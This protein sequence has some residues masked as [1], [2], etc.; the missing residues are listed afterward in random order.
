MMMRLLLC[1]REQSCSWRDRRRV[2]VDGGRGRGGGG[3]DDR[4]VGR[5]VEESGR[6]QEI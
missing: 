6:R 1:V 5:L 3:C 4:V 2:V